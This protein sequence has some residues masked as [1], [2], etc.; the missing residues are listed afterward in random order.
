MK[1]GYNLCKLKN[2]KN[3][4]EQDINLQ[5]KKEAKKKLFQ[6]VLK[7]KDFQIMLNQFIKIPTK[8]VQL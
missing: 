7:I 6:Q 2:I 5:L 3:F 1:N 8:Q 4:L